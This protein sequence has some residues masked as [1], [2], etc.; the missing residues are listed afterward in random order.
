MDRGECALT[1]DW[2]GRFR[3]YLRAGKQQ[4]AIGLSRVPGSTRVLD[5]TIGNLVK[6][7]KERCPFSTWFPDLESWVNFAPYVSYEGYA[8]AVNRFASPERHL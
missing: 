8:C 1:I 6:C 2:G 4:N 7:D 3:Q 5:R